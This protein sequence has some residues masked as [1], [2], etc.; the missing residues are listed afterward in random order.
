MGR[1]PRLPALAARPLSKLPGGVAEE[2]DGGRW[3][4][5]TNS[6]FDS[7]DGLELR[8]TVTKGG[9]GAARGLVL[10]HGGGVTRDEGGFFTRLAAG[11]ARRGAVALRFDFRGHGKSGGHQGV[12]LQTA[13]RLRHPASLAG[14]R[15]NPCLWITACRQIRCLG[16][17]PRAS[18]RRLNRPIC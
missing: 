4:R 2:A 5:G 10:V 18:E 3:P 17:S 12:P 14:S 7:L 16:G 6:T 13:A 11:A 8:G 1:V 9:P 15:E